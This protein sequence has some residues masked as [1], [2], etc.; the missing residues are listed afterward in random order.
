MSM[1]SPSA[2]VADMTSSTSSVT[3]DDYDDIA[4]VARPVMTSPTQHE[5]NGDVI[6]EQPVVDVVM[7]PG[8]DGVVADEVAASY[9]DVTANDVEALSDVVTGR[10]DVKSTRDVVD[11]SE[12]VQND[13][14]TELYASCDGNGQ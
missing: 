1:A 8:C 4:A 9:V 6:Y 3:L 13:D 7:L 11:T 2:S 12:V 10:D 14:E 5:C